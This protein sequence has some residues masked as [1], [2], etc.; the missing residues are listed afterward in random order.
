MS[1]GDR[2]ERL[3][4]QFNLTQAQLAEELGVSLVTVNR[5][6]RG[7]AQ[8]SPAAVRRID[9]LESASRRP[10][11]TAPVPVRAVVGGRGEFLAPPV[12][13]QLVTEAERL[14][15]G[16]LASPAF[17]TETSLIDP[18]PHQRLAV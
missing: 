14:S 12:H 7:H 8:P 3:R 4:R 2:I 9:L 1:D 6:E 18:L 5:W 13:I 15:F 17:A 10:M 11:A 16:Y